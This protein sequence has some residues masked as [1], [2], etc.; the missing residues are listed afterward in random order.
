MAKT[1]HVPTSPANKV[2]DVDIDR[3]AVAFIDR[4]DHLTAAA[5]IDLDNLLE[6]MRPKPSDQE[7]CEPDPDIIAA[8]E[9]TPQDWMDAE[10][11]AEAYEYD[12]KTRAAN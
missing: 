3:A 7:V 1:Y 5:E 4:C 12:R 9:A 2:V 11:P 10:P 8:L 6:R